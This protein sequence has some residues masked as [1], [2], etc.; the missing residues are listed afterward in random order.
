MSRLLKR[1]AHVAV[2]WGVAGSCRKRLKELMEHATQF[3][4][5]YSKVSSVQKK[6]RIGPVGQQHGDCGP[7][8]AAHT[9]S[10]SARQ[11]ACAHVPC[12]AGRSGSRRLPAQTQTTP[13][14][15]QRYLCFGWRH[16]HKL[17]QQG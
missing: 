2:C 4:E 14:A 12:M 1:S 7:K 6:V 3:P 15:Q 10:S 11:A 5:Q 17:L 9:A 8:A 16:A 13:A